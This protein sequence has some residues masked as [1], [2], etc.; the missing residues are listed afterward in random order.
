MLL[1]VSFV[2]AMPAFAFADETREE[3][4]FQ[5]VSPIQ[6]RTQ[7]VE[8]FKDRIEEE[9]AKFANMNEDQLTSY[10]EEKVS[11]AKALEE[12]NTEDKEFGLIEQLIRLNLKLAWLAAAQLAKLV[13]LPCSGILIEYSVFDKDYTETDGIFAWKIKRTD[14][15]KAYIAD[16]SKGLKFELT[17][18]IDLFFSIHGTHDVTNNGS[19]VTVTDVYDF[20]QN[21]SG[22]AGILNG[23]GDLMAKYKVLEEINVTITIS[24]GE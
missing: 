9:R 22:I 5:V 23:I 2:L 14:A 15:Y 4:A 3:R 10:I 8:A 17:D 18:S 11:Y 13:G 19:S 1:L 7:R 16:N 20:D 21:F 12:I 6:Y 24:T